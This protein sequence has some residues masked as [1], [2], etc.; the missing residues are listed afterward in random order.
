MALSKTEQVEHSQPE[1][2]NTGKYIS[3][4]AKGTTY[5]SVKEDIFANVITMALCTY[6][7][8]FSL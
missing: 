7:D 5:Q 3:T 1:I 8:D 4:L 6:T 2:C